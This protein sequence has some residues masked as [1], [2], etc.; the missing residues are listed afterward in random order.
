LA[1]KVV[2]EELFLIKGV[3]KKRI[4][5]NWSDKTITFFIFLTT[6]IVENMAAIT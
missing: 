6:I 3:G 4:M 5:S 1:L 2:L